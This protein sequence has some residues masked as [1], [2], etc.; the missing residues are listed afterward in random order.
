M[1]ERLLNKEERLF[2]EQPRKVTREL[3]EFWSQGHRSTAMIRLAQPHYT[4]QRGMAM[5]RLPGCYLSSE[6]ISIHAKHIWKELRKVSHTG[7]ANI[8]RTALIK[9]P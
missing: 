8:T 1:L 7:S 4:G 3:L 2:T 9:I 6:P 5:L